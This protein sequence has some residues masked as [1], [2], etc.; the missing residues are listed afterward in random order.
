[1]LRLGSKGRR[2]YEITKTIRL[3]DGINDRFE[4]VQEQANDT[5]NTITEVQQKKKLNE[6][7]RC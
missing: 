4:F 5:L 1:M 7:W 2:I 6:R 3:K